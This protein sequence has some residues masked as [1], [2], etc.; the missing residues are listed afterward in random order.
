MT[1]EEYNIGGK[2]TNGE[3]FLGH[4]ETR[5]SP[6]IAHLKKLGDWVRGWKSDEA[7]GGL[8]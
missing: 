2:R 8:R 7:E 6:E 1:S 5:S 4:E 3:P